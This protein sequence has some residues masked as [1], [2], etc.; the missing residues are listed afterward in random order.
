[1]QYNEKTQICNVYFSYSRF[2]IKDIALIV[3]SFRWDQS[4]V[5]KSL[6]ALDAL[7]TEVGWIVNSA[8]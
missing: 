3:E 1:M 6:H 2:K 4:F 7:S 5:A 8:L